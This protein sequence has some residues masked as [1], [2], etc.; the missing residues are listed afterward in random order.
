[1]SAINDRT[2]LHRKANEVLDQ[3][4][5]PGEQI[6]VVVTGPSNQA[7]IGTDRRVFIYK[8]GFMAGATFG[9]EMTS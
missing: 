1:M 7:A 3:N 9:S 4:L 2:R 8:K 5:A 6:E